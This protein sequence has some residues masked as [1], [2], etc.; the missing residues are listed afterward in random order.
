M[1]QNSENKVT[2]TVKPDFIIFDFESLSHIPEEAPILSMGAITGNWKD[3]PE[4][5]RKT[6]F[7][8]AINT[9]NQLKYGL[10]PSVETIKWWESQSESAKHIFSDPNKVDI[11]VALNEFD[12]WCKSNDVTHDT[13]VWIRAPHYDWTILSSLY[14]KVLNKDAYHIPISHWKVRDVRTFC[15]VA[16]NVKNGYAPNRDQLFAS[17]N[18]IEH[19]ALDDCIKEYLQLNQFYSIDL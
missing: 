3:S 8:R 6:G 9:S 18:I 10:K 1:I 13:P 17:V 11:E 16:Y 19:H 2:K 4:K 14:L 15:D 5:L 12:I 7:Y